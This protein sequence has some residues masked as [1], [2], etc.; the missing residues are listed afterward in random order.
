M[1]QSVSPER[2]SRFKA[3]LIFLACTATAALILSAA[4]L[5]RLF[6][7][8]VIKG[9]ETLTVPD[10]QG[11]ILK[12]E[13]PKETEGFQIVRIDQYDEAPIGTVLRQSPAAGSKR[14]S[15]PGMRYATLTLYVSKGRETATVPSLIGSSAGSAVCE[16]LSRGFSYERVER[17]DSAPAGEVIAQSRAAGSVLPKGET[18]MLTVSKG[19]K[20][21][22]I[23]VPPLSGLSLT[24]AKSL[25]EALGLRIGMVTYR[26][27]SGNDAEQVLTQFPLQGTRA[28]KGTEIALT[29]AKSPNEETE[30]CP[31]STEDDIPS[32]P[33]PP[34]EEST[35]EPRQEMREQPQNDKK[36]V[37]KEDRTESSG[38]ALERILDRFFK[39]QFPGTN[40]EP[41]ETQQ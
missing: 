24:E 30:P 12:K 36:R 37:P 23:Q 35:R 26:E 29:I 14:K 22:K 9:S 34:N 15:A 33:S 20:D 6:F 13:M 38:E 1:K 3:I 39:E 2:H 32:E 19:E 28:A 41:T 21:R 10:L 5:F 8:N 25:A 7:G 17:Y 4:L 18:V 31:P 16:L 27:A 40:Q 11:V